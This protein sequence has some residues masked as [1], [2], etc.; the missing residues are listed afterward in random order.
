M[1]TSR[2]RDKRRGTKY[3]GILR[4]NRSRPTEERPVVEH[5]EPRRSPVKWRLF[6]G[7]IVVTL[8]LVLLLFFSA[9]AFYVRSIAVGG[10]K[11]LTKEEIFA[12]ADIANVHI[13]WINP[14]QVREN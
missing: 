4:D 12:Y 9:D 13:F 6:S 11:Y 10:M 5:S 3:A 1:S 2:M 8:A 14:E 7:M